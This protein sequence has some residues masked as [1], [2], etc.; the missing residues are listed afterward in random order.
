VKESAHPIVIEASAIRA[1]E[2]MMARYGKFINRA[3][4]KSGRIDDEPALSIEGWAVLFN[5]PIALQSGEIVVF[6]RGCFDK[7][8]ANRKT[9]FLLAHDSTQVVGST[10]SGLE[11]Y[12]AEAGLAYR[13]PLNNRRYAST[14]KSNVQSNS[15]SAI[16]VGIT[17]SIER[18]E[19][20]GKH[21][22]VFIQYAELR[23]C[24]LVGEGCCEQSFASLI[25][26]NDSPSL[27]DSINSPSFKLESVAHNVRTQ[28]TKR[29]RMLAA[30]TDRV[31]VLQAMPQPVRSMT[32]HKANRLQTE[33]YDQMRTDRRAKLRNG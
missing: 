14:I 30:I 26:A 16:S 11:L 18:I 12:V 17:R 4:P 22:V 7:H 20:I 1:R 27:K 10:D 19:K 32:V 13:M 2:K 28:F 8:L 6:E 5:E 25:D 29:M 31:A 24:S 3:Y 33:W 15:Q 23:E 21:N 9:D